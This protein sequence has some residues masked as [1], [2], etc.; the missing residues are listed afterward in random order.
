MPPTRPAE[1]RMSREICMSRPPVTYE[2]PAKLGQTWAR[3][4]AFRPI[5]ALIMVKEWLLRGTAS[6][7]ANMQRPP[8]RAA[9]LTARRSQACGWLASGVGRLRRSAMNWSN[10]VLS[11]AKRRRSRN[12]RNSRCSS[13]SR[14][15]RLGA[16]F[17]EGA[18]AARRR[19]IPRTAAH[20]GAH[21]VHLALHALHLVLPAVMAAVIP[22]SHSSAPYREGEDGKAKRPPGHEAE[23][24]QRDPGGFAEFVELRGDGHCRPRVNVNNIYIARPGQG[25]CQAAR[26][27][28]WEAWRRCQ[29]CARKTRWLQ[30]RRAAAALR[31]SPRR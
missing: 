2:I 20:F 22:A 24:D 9:S 21:P 16:V 14:R 4:L 23:N 5:T 31:P 27:L 19:I 30:R 29:T 12:S 1:G 11:L 10:S 28:N 7:R 3:K 25:P 18:V 26:T 17:V 6:T 8:C 13:S 15:R